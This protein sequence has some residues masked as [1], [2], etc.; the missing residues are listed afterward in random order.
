[1]YKSLLLVISTL[2]GSAHAIAGPPEPLRSE[3]LAKA[4]QAR[5]G[6]IVAVTKPGPIAAETAWLLSAQVVGSDKHAPLLL[7][8]NEDKEKLLQSLELH[9]NALP[10]LI[11]YDRSGR[12]INRI[13]GA[14]PSQLIKQA[15]NGKSRLN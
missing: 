8:L 3:I 5:K 6:V 9:E 10:A 2:L 12:E 4:Q 14:L 11:Y 1:M 15:R 7:V 13:I